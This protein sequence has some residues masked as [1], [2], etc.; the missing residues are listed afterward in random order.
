[1][2]SKKPL[3]RGIALKSY[4]ASQYGLR[5]IPYVPRIWVL[6]HDTCVAN[7][8]RTLIIRHCR[9][10]PDMEHAKA[11][12]YIVDPG[13]GQFK[14]RWQVVMSPVRRI[15]QLRSVACG[16]AAELPTCKVNAFPGSLSVTSGKHRK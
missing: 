4:R 1:M 13:V 10:M 7:S 2:T 9:Y 6:Q 12:H 16:T 15:Q 8:A 3:S 5:H 14:G 11:L